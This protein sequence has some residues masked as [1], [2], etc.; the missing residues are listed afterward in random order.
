MVALGSRSE[1]VMSVLS[2]TEAYERLG[3]PKIADEFRRL[4]LDEEVRTLI[5]SEAVLRRWADAQE[6]GRDITPTALYSWAAEAACAGESGTVPVMARWLTVQHCVRRPGGIDALLSRHRRFVE[7]GGYGEAEYLLSVLPAV[8]FLLAEEG[9]EEETDEALTH[10]EHSGD[11]LAWGLCL[12]WVGEGRQEAVGRYVRAESVSLRSGLST[13]HG[14]ARLRRRLLVLALVCGFVT[15]E[16]PEELRELREAFRRRPRSFTALYWG[17][18]YMG[19]LIEDALGLELPGMRLHQEACRERWYFDGVVE[20]LRRGESP[21]FLPALLVSAALR[22]HQVAQWLAEEPATGPTGTRGVRLRVL[23]RRARVPRKSLYAELLAKVPSGEGRF[24]DSAEV[25]ALRGLLAAPVPVAWRDGLLFT[26]LMVVMFLVEYLGAP[27]WSI[28]LGALP[29]GVALGGVL[30]VER[31]MRTWSRLV[32]LSPRDG[33]EKE[34]NEL[35]VLIP[36][37]PEVPYTHILS[38]L[39]SESHWRTRLKPLWEAIA[40]RE[41]V[42]ADSYLASRLT[43]QLG[44]RAIHSADDVSYFLARRLPSGRV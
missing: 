16:D 39:Y 38:R 4:V 12:G 22:S 9:R 20:R 27:W 23:L 41:V 24:F 1:E 35:Y 5:T 33:G 6:A 37:T 7:E 2:L 18:E 29:T 26:V 21:G 17:D 32:L 10:L 8:V 43:L 19:A 44:R 34:R 3:G 30:T 40:F 28:V 15:E 25:R 11:H 13:L 31:K 36:D 14:D 42:Q